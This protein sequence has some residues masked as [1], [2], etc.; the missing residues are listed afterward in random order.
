MRV[1]Q[2]LPKRSPI[3]VTTSFYG[4]RRCA[5][6]QRQ[7]ANPPVRWPSPQHRTACAVP[8]PPVQYAVTE[9]SMRLRDPGAL[10]AERGSLTPARLDSR[11]R[12]MGRPAVGRFGGVGDPRRARVGITQGYFVSC[13]SEE[14]GATFVV[15]GASS[16]SLLEQDVP[17]VFSLLLI[18]G[19][20]LRQEWGQASRFHRPCVG[21][22]STVS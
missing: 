8:L 3:S 14:V 1:D 21:G 10:S 7:D 15:A 9:H 4:F 5:N 18:T 2:D 19:D 17:Y 20:V 13:Q 12:I 11:P 22:A 16:G 6:W